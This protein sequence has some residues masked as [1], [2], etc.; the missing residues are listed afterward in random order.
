[1]RATVS[2]RI[3]SIGRSNWRAARFATDTAPWLLISVTT[4]TSVLLATAALS[5]WTPP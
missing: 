3:T 5:S 1:M 4:T 2:L